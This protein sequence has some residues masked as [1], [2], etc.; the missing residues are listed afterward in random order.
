MSSKKKTV[1]E[2][3]PFAVEPTATG[4]KDDLRMASESIRAQLLAAIVR[5]KKIEVDAL[6]KTFPDFTRVNN[7]ASRPLPR[8]QRLRSQ[9]VTKSFRRD[10]EAPLSGPFLIQSASRAE[11]DSHF[12]LSLYAWRKGHR[13][14]PYQRSA[15]PMRRTPAKCHPFALF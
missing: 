3:K 12:A 15:I 8:R 2:P 4:K 1:K 5:A 7:V 9:S 6:E 13:A 14:S 10:H 11:R